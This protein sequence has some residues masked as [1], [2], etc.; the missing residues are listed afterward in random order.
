MIFDFSR[1]CSETSLYPRGSN[2]AELCGYKGTSMVTCKTML[3]LSFHV[4]SQ[5][6]KNLTISSHDAD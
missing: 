5:K 3:G 4:K 1:F 2:H 6:I